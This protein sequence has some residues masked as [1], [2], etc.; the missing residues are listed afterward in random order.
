[1]IASALIRLLVKEGVRVHAVCRPGSAKLKNIPSSELVTVHQLDISEM[2]K[3]PSEID[4]ADAFFHFAWAGTGGTA[5]NDAFLQDRNITFTLEACRAAADCGCSVFLGAGSQAEYG[6]VTG[7]L[8]SDTPVFPENGYG[9]AKLAAGQL[10]RLLANNLGLRHE[11]LRILSVYGPGDNDFT[12][13]SSSLKLFLSGKHAPFTPGE[14]LWDFLYC[15]D[16][17]RAFYLAAG[18]GRDGAVYP[19]GS[20]AARPL[21]EYIGLMCEACGATD[22]PGFGELPYNENQV[23]RLCADIS[24]L[25]EDCGFEPLVPYEEGIKRTVAYMKAGVL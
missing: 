12:I 20:G 14:Q 13:T 19:L 4:R 3:L 8:K 6:R 10:S 2:G 25:R 1:M 21:K 9:M 17:A 23:M 5:R 24:G 18:K 11:W 22:R 15:D 7:D 16:A